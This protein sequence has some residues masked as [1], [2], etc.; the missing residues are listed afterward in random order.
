MANQRVSITD[1]FPLSCELLWQGYEVRHIVQ[2]SLRRSK[3]ISVGIYPRLFAR[4]RG[5][6]CGIKSGHLL[7]LVEITKGG[8]D[9]QLDF[10]AH[11]GL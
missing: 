7:C 3:A 4:R 8:R 11:G 9:K 10:V 2:A 5:W 6:P 1:V